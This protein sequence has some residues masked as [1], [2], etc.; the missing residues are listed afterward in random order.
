MKGDAF[1]A[2]TDIEGAGLIDEASVEVHR[3]R[4]AAEGSMEVRLA[5]E[6]E[7][8]L[9]S[10]LE[11]GARHDGGDGETGFGLDLGGGF[12]YRDYARGL[13]IE[14]S[15]RGLLVHDGNIEEW[16]GS[17]SVLYDSG[18]DGRGLSFSLLPSYGKAQGG[19]AHLYD[20]GVRLGADADGDDAAA[21]RL[22]VETGYGIPIA[23]HRALLTPYAG[24]SWAD[25]GSRQDRLGLRLQL[26][27][28]AT[29]GLE[30]ARDQR[31]SSVPEHSVTLRGEMQW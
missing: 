18:A 1:W 25:E 6:R 23:H 27:H 17:L 20:N 2:R 11:L 9:T 10:T 31:P 15:G 21:L 14:G 30:F 4:V 8:T 3:V 13:T 28:G 7:R 22:G 29:F 24:A 5:P 12:S 19:T 26:R 16:G